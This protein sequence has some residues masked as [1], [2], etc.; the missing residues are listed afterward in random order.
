M[1]GRAMAWLAAL[2]LAGVVEAEETFVTIGTGGQTGVY[3]ATGQSICAFLNQR[4][5]EHG[6]RCNA[7]ASGGGI[8]NVHGMRNG[9]FDFGVMQA[10]HLF[11]AREGIGPFH[12]EVAMSDIR[13]LFSLQREVFTVLARRDAG[14][15]GLD[16]LQGKRI[17]IGNSGSGQRDTLEE[18]MVAKGW[19][20]STFALASEL[21]AAEQ[22]SALGEDNI[23]AM[24]YFVGHPNGAIEE[25]TDTVDAVLVPVT[26]EAV[27]RLLAERTYY[28][29]AEIP[30]GLYKGNPQATPSIG[31]RAVLATSANTDPQVVYELVK[32]V[33]DNLERLRELHP[34]L[35]ELQTSEMIS[36]GLTA[37]LHEGAERYYRERGW[38]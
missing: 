5:S 19:D 30:A 6:I 8:A 24:T 31:T 7:T 16:D 11:K 35:A 17:N 14:I 20:R 37:P 18:I 32:A 10:D 27:E 25:A 21:K 13:A 34:A 28:S 29:R 3:F 12:G 2:M 23:D 33:F 36:T 9:E 26:G 4:S 1:R 38:L 22:A 15:Q